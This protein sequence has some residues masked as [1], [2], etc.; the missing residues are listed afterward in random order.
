M[1]L[2]I[3]LDG[4]YLPEEKAVVS[5][6]DHGLLY[7]DGVFEGIR[8]YHG[9]VFKLKEHIDRLYESAK[10]ILLKIPLSREEM[11]EVVLE[12][13]RR[14]NIR[15]GYIRLVVTRGRG[16]LGLDPKKCPRPTV[17]CIAASI[18]LYPPEFYERG[19]EVITV[20]T[21]RNVPE[22]LN[23][24]IKSLNYLNN[25]LAKI[26]AGLY[27]VQE[28]IMLTSDGYVAEATGDNIFIV[29]NGKL[30]TPPPHLGILEGITRNTVM[31]LAR[32]KGMAVFEKTFT[33]HDVFIADECFLTGTAAE[34]I[35]VVKVDGR[36]IGDGR[37]GAVTWELI[38]AFRELTEVDGPAIYPE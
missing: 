21:R 24:R 36:P 19:L 30:I 33:R 18:Q 34:I 3:Y 1:G 38:H 22:A 13:C 5:V 14:N 35:P 8:A 16:D 9:R 10:S 4:E 12:T 31:A 28:A 37:P 20:P 7:G 17:F 32:E 29:K 23:P 26:E 6:F 15:D 11:Q 25:I 2:T 27:G